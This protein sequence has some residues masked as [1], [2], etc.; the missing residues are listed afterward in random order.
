MTITARDVVASDATSAYGRLVEASLGASSPPERKAMANG[1]AWFVIATA[2][3]VGMDEA[4]A[5]AALEAWADII[6]DVGHKLLDDLL[7]DAEVIYEDA[8]AG[9]LL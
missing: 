8:I 3:L 9:V 2:C 5:L 6:D 7:R 4:E 1:A